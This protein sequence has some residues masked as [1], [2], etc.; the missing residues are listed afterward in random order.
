MTDKNKMRHLY[1]D[2]VRQYS[3]TCRLC[4]HLDDL[5]EKHKRMLRQ[6][7]SDMVCGPIPQD[8]GGAPR[9]TQL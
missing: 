9:R 7:Y 3:K 6:A 1:R 2:V 8:T 4:K 5:C